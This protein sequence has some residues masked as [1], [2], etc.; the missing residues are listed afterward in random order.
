MVSL[1]QSFDKIRFKTKKDVKKRL[2]LN[3]KVTFNDLLG[4]TV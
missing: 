2:V 4:H 3:T 1:K